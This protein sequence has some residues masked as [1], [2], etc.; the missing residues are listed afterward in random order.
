[1]WSQ[2]RTAKVKRANHRNLGGE[3]FR[4]N[5]FRIEQTAWRGGGDE[6]LHRKENEVGFDARRKEEMA[7]RAAL[8]KAEI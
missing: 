2:G 6:R 8:T 5:V 4:G 1:M 3:E 7:F